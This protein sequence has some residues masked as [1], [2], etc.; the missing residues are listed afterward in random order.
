LRGKAL[1]TQQGDGQFQHEQGQRTVGRREDGKTQ[2]I[3]VKN[4]EGPPEV[5]YKSLSMRKTG[6]RFNT[7]A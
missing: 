2:R 7:I 3:E 5:K 6:R 1:V 4:R